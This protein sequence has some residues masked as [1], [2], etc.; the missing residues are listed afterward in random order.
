[1]KRSEIKIST[2]DR[3][4]EFAMEVK[5]RKQVYVGQIARD[6]LSPYQ[7][8]KRILIMQESK[9]LAELLDRRGLTW[10]EMINIL[11]AASKPK[12]K[13]KQSTFQFPS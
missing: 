2:K 10:E 12:E 1:M 7:A 11:E 3:V 5:M 4:K 8:N 9:E 6:K 13:V